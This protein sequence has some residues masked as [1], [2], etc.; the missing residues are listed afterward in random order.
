MRQLIAS[1]CSLL[2]L[3]VPVFAEPAAAGA[4]PPEV[5]PLPADLAKRIL[6]LVATAEKYRGLAAKA[7]VPA[8]VIEEAALR[9][10][11]AAE[12][13]K[14]LPPEELRAVEAGLEAF[15]LI[16]QGLDLERYYPELLLSQVV[17]Y[18]DPERKYLSVVHREGSLLGPAGGNIGEEE[19]LEEMVLVHELTH[20]LQDQ[21][22][23]LRSF[24]E[25]DLLSDAATA[26]LALVEGDAAVTM[27]EFYLGMPVTSIPGAAEALSSLA[28]SSGELMEASPDLPGARELAGAPA[29]LRDMLLFSYLEG[30]SFC[31]SVRQKGGQVL[32]DRAFRDDPPRSSEQV[33]HPEKWH[34]LRDDPVAIAMPSLSGRLPGF[35]KVSEGELGEVGIRILLR[36]AGKDADRA[37]IADIAAAGWGGD[38][39]AVYEKDGR[40]VL[41]W[42]T[43]WDTEADARELLAA[44]KALGRDWRAELTGPLRVVILRGARAREAAALRPLL[45]EVK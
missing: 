1:F 34:T 13:R 16:P 6:E 20:A 22:F 38:R 3:A 45:A 42:V 40:R 23:D 8:G 30:Y 29:W 7:P 11:V 44:A 26:R 14:E 37:K 21:H 27:F 5:A 15:G 24:I 28:G 36:E 35:R 19:K 12:V 4:L 9:S 10:Q 39:F 18:Y 33:L 31:V 2:L 43:E 41:A 32:L 17:G 25:P